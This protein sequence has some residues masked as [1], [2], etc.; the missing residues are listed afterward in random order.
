LTINLGEA[1]KNND[2]IDDNNGQKIIMKKDKQKIELQITDAEYDALFLLTDD[3]AEAECY[4]DYY[5]DTEAFLFKQGNVTMCIRE[6]GDTYTMTMTVA[7]KGIAEV[8]KYVK[9]IDVKAF[10]FSIKH[11]IP[12][13]LLE[14]LPLKWNKSPLEYREIIFFACSATERRYIDIPCG[15]KIAITETDRVRT[16]KYAIEFEYEEEQELIA[17]KSFLE[18]KHISWLPIKKNGYEQLIDAWKQSFIDDE[19]ELGNEV[20]ISF[21]SRLIPGFTHERKF[22]ISLR[23]KEGQFIKKVVVDYVNNEFG[24][25]S[26]V[27]QEP[28]N[29]LEKAKYVAKNLQNALEKTFL[30][31]KFNDSRGFREDSNNY[32]F[33][34][35]TQ[36]EYLAIRQAEIDY[37]HIVC[38]IID[39]N[40]RRIADGFADGLNNRE[41]AGKYF[42]GNIKKA[43]YEIG[44]FYKRL[45][46]A[47]ARMAIVED[48]RYPS[49]GQLS[50]LHQDYICA[51]F[52]I[53]VA[54]GTDDWVSLDARGADLYTKL[55]IKYTCDDDLEKEPDD[56]AKFYYDLH[57]RLFGK[58]R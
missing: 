39:N 38:S 26:I 18:A 55:G 15:I 6:C 19:E 2:K 46:E 11:S 50:P 22:K 37:S 27:W 7:K 47:Y 52:H 36:K 10:I 25:R 45:A 34:G 29:F 16:T 48:A 41:I 49:F 23:T 28:Q 17:V 12:H 43:D 58:G 14:D 57:D 30:S 40:F 54:V 51:G 42:D 3:D 33:F 32:K 31:D 44:K 56:D 9:L 1:N 4:T 53:M 5:F 24:V 21:K 13:D 20:Q 35:L 8:K